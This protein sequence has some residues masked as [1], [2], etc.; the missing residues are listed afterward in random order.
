MQN[1]GGSWTGG[2]ARNEALTPLR[3]ICDEERQYR[4]AGYV[5]AQ[6]QRLVDIKAD[7]SDREKI[8][9]SPGIQQRQ[10]FPSGTLT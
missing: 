7:V 1:L 5:E 8:Q 4:C 6:L 3:L 10:Y 9:S 2:R